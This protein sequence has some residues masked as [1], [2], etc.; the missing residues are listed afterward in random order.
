[1]MSF[2]FHYPL[3]L[4]KPIHA[5]GRTLPPLL[6]TRAD[7]R[8][9]L[10]LSAGGP[11]NSWRLL[12]DLFFLWLGDISHRLDTLRPALGLLAIRP[13]PLPSPTYALFKTRC[14][15][16]SAMSK[17]RRP[18]QDCSRPVL[19]VGFPHGGHL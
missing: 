4:N 6:I 8:L 13:Q 12:S 15:V 19:S 7:G 18:A 9:L 2:P 10:R 11:M 17:T 16:P 1:M 14:P 3:V 5:Y